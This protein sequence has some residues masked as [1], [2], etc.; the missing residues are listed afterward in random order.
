MPLRRLL[1]ALAVATLPVTSPAEALPAHA[2]AFT[3]VG[4]HHPGYPLTGCAEQYWHMTVATVLLPDPMGYPSHAISFE[5]ASTQ[6]V[7]LMSD[8]GSLSVSADDDGDRT[9]DIVGYG[10]FVRTSSHWELRADI[11]VNGEPHVLSCRAEYTYTS[12]NPSTSFV[13]DGACTLL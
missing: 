7:T 6:C 13:V 5:G 1:A 11:A 10:D 3:G 12:I 2:A 8:A 4:T 9:L